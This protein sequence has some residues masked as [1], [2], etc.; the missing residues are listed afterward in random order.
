MSY[1]PGPTA[2]AWH[3]I[4]T[5]TY[6]PIAPQQTATASVSWATNAI[7]YIPTVVPRACTV[8]KLW[9]NFSVATGDGFYLGLYD[10][11]GTRLTSGNAS[12]STSHMV[13]DVTDVTIGPGIYYLATLINSGSGD[14]Y[15]GYTSTTVTQLR[16]LGIYYESGSSLPAT[17]TFSQTSYS[18]LPVLGMYLNTLVS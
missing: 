10:L 18:S 6:G 9:A 15:Y 4:D 13:I 17:A 1:S 16:A 2:A 5:L 8:K 7:L 11:A 14:T 12:A 3:S